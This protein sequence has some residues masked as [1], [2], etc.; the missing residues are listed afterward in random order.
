MVGK[1]QRG[2]RHPSSMSCRAFPSCSWGP[3]I[4]RPL[5]GRPV[6]R[7]PG[8]A[9]SF[10]FRCFRGCFFLFGTSLCLCSGSYPCLC[11]YLAG[12]GENHPSGS[13]H[14]FLT[15]L[16]CLCVLWSTKQNPLVTTFQN[17]VL[18]LRQVRLFRFF[19]IYLCAFLFP[20]LFFFTW[21]PLNGLDCHTQC[22]PMS[23][24][25][26]FHHQSSLASQSLHLWPIV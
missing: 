3:R 10:F 15:S 22:R 6:I 7:F 18:V 2:Y 26:I 11:L 14:C 20:F 23:R 24:N 5:T 19:W 16:S 8:M 13:H 1:I 17:L 21:W 4:I 9:I 12:K 25:M